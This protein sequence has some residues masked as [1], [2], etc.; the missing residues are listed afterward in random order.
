MILGAI[1]RDADHLGVAGIP[2]VGELRDRAEFGGADRR[3][4]LGVREQDRPVV[5]D[6]FV[7]RKRA[8]VCFDFKIG[9]GVVDAQAHGVASLRV[10]DFGIL[11]GPTRIDSPGTVSIN[12]I[13]PKWHKRYLPLNPEFAAQSIWQTA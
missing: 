3:E 1:D 5:A 11:I 8:L 13:R 9:D 4:I 7:Q 6:E 12:S 10:R 2:F